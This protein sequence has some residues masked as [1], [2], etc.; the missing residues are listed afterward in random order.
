MVKVVAWYDNE[1]GYSNRVVDL[2]QRL[3]V[4]QERSGEIAMRTLRGPRRLDGQAGA[5]AGRLQRAA[6][7]DGERVVADDTRIRAALPTIEELRGRGARAGAGLAPR[8]AQGPRAGAVA[9]AGRASGWPSCSGAPVTLAPAVVGRR[10]HGAGGRARARATCCCSRTSATSRARPR[11]I[12][13][14]RARWPR[15]PTSTSTTR[16]APRTARTRSTEGV[17]HLLAE[18]AAGLLLER[19]VTHADASCSRIPRGRSSRSLGGAKVSDKIGVIDRFLRARRHDPDRRRDVLPVPG[20]PRATRSA[21]RCA[22]RRTSSS[23]RTLLARVE[24]PRGARWS[25]RS[26]S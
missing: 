3:S 22:P 1:W 13:S 7:P 12:P 6:R 14:S 20:A 23:P 5:R 4:C 10:G 16:S 25:C 26:T 18:R 2:V 19:E 17:A 24:T 21:T 8:P 9:G 15:S 11:T